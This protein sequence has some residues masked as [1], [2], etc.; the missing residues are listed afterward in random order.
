VDIGL[1]CG[2]QRS[3]RIGTGM[4]SISSLMWLALAV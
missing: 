3:S 4:I 2:S 1:R